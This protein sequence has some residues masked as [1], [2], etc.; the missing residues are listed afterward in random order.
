[1][2]A[3]FNIKSISLFCKP[4]K[5]VKPV[6]NVSLV[7]LYKLIIGDKYKK[8]TEELRSF[9]NPNVKRDYKENNFD[10][11]TGSGIFPYRAD[12]ALK[13]HSEYIVIDLDHLKDALSETMAKL[14]SDDNLYVLLMFV[15]PS[16]D[17]LKVVYGIDLSEG[18]HRKWF[19]AIR[20]YL[21]ETYNLEADHSGI[22]ESRTCFL[23][24]DP[25]CYA[26]KEI[27]ELI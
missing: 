25:E 19:K 4:A 5:T 1:M 14:I 10:F 15:S 16:G 6:E 22:N 17:G 9:E 20:N 8:V 13:Y 24:H 2:E 12:D 3:N 21:R 11:F 18:G 27:R 7:D 26:C 23:A